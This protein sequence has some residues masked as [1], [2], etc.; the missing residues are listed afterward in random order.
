[1]KK[2]SQSQKIFEH[3]WN[4]NTL[5]PIEALERFGCF[6]LSARIKNLRDDGLDI[7]TDIITTKSGKRVAQ[8]YLE[9]IICT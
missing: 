1:M 3:L 2:I 9:N 5:T 6:R 4:G 7:K 8:Y